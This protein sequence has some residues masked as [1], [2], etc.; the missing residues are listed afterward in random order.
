M[1]HHGDFFGVDVAVGLEVVEAAAHAPRPGGDAAPLVRLRLGVKAVDAVGKAVVVVG[2][3][4]SVVDRG[5]G[6]AAL[7]DF[8]DGPARAA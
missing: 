1:A 6:V 7:E 3:N 4:I 5:Q 8:F 2:V